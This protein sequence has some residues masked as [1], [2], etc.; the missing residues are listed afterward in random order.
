MF[1]G[2]HQPH[3]KDQ[4]AGGPNLRSWQHELLAKLAKR[5]KQKIVGQH[6]CNAQPAKA[7]SDPSALDLQ[8]GYTPFLETLHSIKGKELLRMT[9]TYTDYVATFK[10]NQWFQ[11]K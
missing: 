4:G 8:Y 2:N 3:L 10:A 11:V 7:P 5:A 6:R 1:L 9:P